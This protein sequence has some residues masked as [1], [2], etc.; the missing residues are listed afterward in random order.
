MAGKTRL[1]QLAQD[2]AV[3]GQIAFFDSGNGQWEPRLKHSLNN[4]VDPNGNDDTTDGYE[5]GS[6]WVNTTADTAF[7]CLDATDTAAVWKEVTGSAGDQATVQARRTTAY[8]LTTSFADVTLDT[9]DV[10]NE[11]AVLDHDLATNS[12]RIL[13]GDTGPYRISY[14]I[15]LPAPPA[16]TTQEV[17][18]RIRVNDTTVLVGSEAQETVVEDTQITGSEVSG[19]VGKTFIASLTSGDFITLQLQR[20]EIGG[21]GAFSTEANLIVTAT[22]LSGEKGAKGVQGPGGTDDDAIHD[23]VAGEINAIAEKTAPVAADLLIIED[24]AASNA[25]KKVQIGNLPTV[26][27]LLNF[28]GIAA[29]GDTGKHFEVEGESN[30]STVGALDQRVE[31]VIPKT[32]TLKHLGWNSASASATTVV[33]VI[34]NSVVVATIT[35]T[36]TSGVDTS[37]SIDFTEGT[38]KVAVEYDAGTAPGE[39]SINLYFEAS[40]T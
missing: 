31:A 7:V 23:N 21:T 37:L 3:D 29:G 12:D 26:G 34:K 9:T 40:I 16:N 25:K 22:R 36:G 32:A 35:L 28:G 38:D 20:V 5:P 15:D 33:K 30:A 24:S 6:I 19:H 17:L 2:A 27:Y 8:A 13:I 4:A 14:H 10:E 39:T 18:G 11:T 1:E